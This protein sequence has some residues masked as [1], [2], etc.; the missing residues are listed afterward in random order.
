MKPKSKLPIRSV[1]DQKNVL[2]I[3]TLLSVFMFCSLSLSSPVFASGD[4]HEIATE[5]LDVRPAN[6]RAELRKALESNVQH[7]KVQDRRKLSQ[8]EREALHRDLRAVMRNVNADYDD[9]HK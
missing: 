5:S 1:Q 8:E 2:R 6:R 7:D 9:G 4:A 3:G